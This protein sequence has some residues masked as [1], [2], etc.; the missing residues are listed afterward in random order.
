MNTI[1]KFSIV[2]LIALVV[3][4][5]SSDTEEIE[6]AAASAEGVGV[7]FFDALYN[8]NDLNKTMALCTPSFAKE[9]NKYGTTKNAARRLFNMSF[10]SVRIDSALGD[11][12]VREDFVN[13]GGLTFLFTGIRNG[14]TYKDLKSIK[15]IK[16]G[17][18]WLV[19]EVLKDPMPR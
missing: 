16:K 4:S 3:C 11:F 15:L 13:S 9:I 7:A 17:N 1:K 5:C 19:D 10:D 14:K 8:Q 18:A 2:V 6:D 12:K